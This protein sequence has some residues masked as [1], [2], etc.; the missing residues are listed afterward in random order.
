MRIHFIAIGGS[1]MHNLAIA[2]HI[3][4]Y[5]ITGSDDHIFEPSRSRLKKY[6]LLPE[7]EG[8]YPEKITKDI[9]VVVVGMH[10]H[11]DNP[12]LEKAIQLGIKTYSYPE[13][14]YEQ[15][16]DKKR[17]VIGGS[18]GKTTT[19]SMILHILESSGI[20]FDYMVGAQLKGFEVMVKLTDDAEVIIM[21]GD[22]YLSSPLDPRPKFHLYRPHIA[23][24]TGI[25]WDHIN[26]FPTFE[27]YLSQ[28]EKFIELI[29]PNG[30]LYHY[31]QDEALNRIVKD[32]KDDINKVSYNS[33]K[34]SEQ[35]YN[36]NQI[37][38]AGQQIPLKVFG[39]HNLA[40]LQLAIKICKEL[41][42]SDE[43]IIQA[44]PHFEGASNRLELV[45]SNEDITIYKDF[46]HAPSK[47][48]A[49]VEAIKKQY[50]QREIIA[51]L[52]LHTYS[53]LNKKFMSEYSGTMDKADLPIIYFN[54]KTVER[55]RLPKLSGDDIEQGFCNDDL[56]IFTSPEAFTSYING[57]INK[58]Q[59]FLFMSS[60]D[61]GGVDIKELSK[62]ILE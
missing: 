59:V 13:F 43:T 50:P 31:S 42:V 29:E 44:I 35:D 51:C 22:E 56:I 8:W 45:D 6:N 7:K 62:K 58:N 2:L 37:E 54:P 1:A 11:K 19:T 24:I 39:D 47:L 20:K 49:T 4:G 17:V 32:S 30:T 5:Q 18:H 21:E 61:F 41:G 23:A 25:A 36:L 53:S 15:S 34:S 55:K 38:Y 60:G 10:A 26:V 52:E 48:K 33:L 9:D 3:K 28:F 14:L 27:N 57:V 16:R 40:N 46:A 12:E